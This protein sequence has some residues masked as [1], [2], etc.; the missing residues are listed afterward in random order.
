LERKGKL[1]IDEINV[2]GQKGVGSGWVDGIS[3]TVSANWPVMGNKFPTRCP[4]HFKSM[5]FKV[6]E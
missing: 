4:H 6:R 2:I 1:D 3:S 5:G